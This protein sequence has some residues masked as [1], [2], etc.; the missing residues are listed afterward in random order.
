ML[1]NI[2]AAEMH[3]FE[4]QS[5]ARNFFFDF[6]HRHSD[7][8]L[9]TSIFDTGLKNRLST[10]TQSDTFWRYQKKSIF[11]GK[12]KKLHFLNLK[13]AKLYRKVSFQGSNWQKFPYFLNV[14][15]KRSKDL[16]SALVKHEPWTSLKN[17]NLILIST[18]IKHR[19][20]LKTAS[21]STGFSSISLIEPWISA[22]WPVISDSTLMGVLDLKLTSLSPEKILLLSPVKL[23][24]YLSMSIGSTCS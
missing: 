7:R 22:S 4:T 23:V 2:S 19:R 5:R 14:I 12:I 10:L 13:K 18:Y 9:P 6:W 24:M 8:R 15:L 20:L 11:M 3:T 17:D 1:S 16:G 21:S